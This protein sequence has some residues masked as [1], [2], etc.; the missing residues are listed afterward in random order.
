LTSQWLQF[1]KTTS[2]LHLCELLHL[3]ALCL[4]IINQTKNPH[5]S[6]VKFLKSLQISHLALLQRRI[7]SEGANYT[8]VSSSVNTFRNTSRKDL[9]QYRPSGASPAQ[10]SG[11]LSIG[12]DG[13]KVT[14]TVALQMLNG[15]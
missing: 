2:V 8:D 7:S 9:S 5:L 4:S 12:V 1:L 11:Y 13:I 15:N 3:L 10:E 14:E 6:I